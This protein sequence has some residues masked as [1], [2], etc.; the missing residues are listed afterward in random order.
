[1]NRA[2]SV[3]VQPNGN[4]TGQ[5]AHTKS[6]QGWEGISAFHYSAP[7]CGGEASLQGRWVQWAAR[8]GHQGHSG[9]EQGGVS[10]SP[11]GPMASSITLHRTPLTHA[12]S[13]GYRLHRNPTVKW[14]FK[15]QQNACRKANLNT[16]KFYCKYPR[17]LPF[18]NFFFMKI[19]VNHLSFLFFC[20]LC[21]RDA[22]QKNWGEGREDVLF[23]S[24]LWHL[25]TMWLLC[26]YVS[27][28]ST[29]SS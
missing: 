24:L 25:V 11:D 8:S 28:K 1:M 14:G 23:L 18:S 16:K 17:C 4:A 15:E 13:C 20:K 22:L 6:R 3:T 5:A 21:F 7:V 27:T 29:W 2:I 9:S 26:D 10:Y 19:K 12:E